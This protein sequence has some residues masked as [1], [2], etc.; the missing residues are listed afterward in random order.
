MAELDIK[1]KVAEAVK[2]KQKDK[3]FKDTS[4]VEYTRKYQAQYD[5]ITSKDLT[6]IEKDPITAYKL[7]D[8]AKIW[9]AYNVDQMK[10]DG[11][12]SGVAYLA[13]KVRESLSTKPEDSPKARELYVESVAA[14]IPILESATDIEKLKDLLYGFYKSWGKIITDSI[15]DKTRYRF[16]SSDYV[17]DKS[18]E[19][20]WGKRFINQLKFSS[21]AAKTVYLEARM[22]SAFSIEEQNEVVKTKE[23]VYTERI[24]R[25]EYSI[26]AATSADSEEILKPVLSQY[27]ITYD[28]KI[29]LQSNKDAFIERLNKLIASS[30]SIIQNPELKP[31]QLAREDDWK[32]HGVKKAPA[33]KEEKDEWS[34]NILDFYGLKKAIKTTSLSYIK[35][36]Y[37]LPVPDINVESIREYFGYS[38]VVF[39][40]YV[41]DAESKE[42]VRHFLG[43]MVD[44]AEI[45]NVD[46]KQINKFGNLAIFFGALGCGSFSSA[47]ACYYPSRKA[48]NLTKKTGDGSLAHEWSHYLDN[49]CGESNEKRTDSRYASSGAAYLDNTNIKN[50]FQRLNA[51]IKAGPDFELGVV[52]SR[53]RK[54]K[55]PKYR[56]YGSTI[57][58]CVAAIQ[59]MYPKYKQYQTV[60]N[61][62]KAI[63]Y[64]RYIATKFNVDEIV[65]PMVSSTT[66]YY[67]V[68]S[69]YE[70]SGKLYW[71][72]PVELF[73][74]AFESYME[75]KL[76]QQER[77]SNYLVSI[78]NN[79]GMAAV[80]IPKEEWPYPQGAELER[81]VVAFDNL[82]KTIKQEF[83]IGDFSWF[84]DV[85][86][87]EYI[88]LANTTDEKIEAGVIVN[89]EEQVT[90]ID[91][92]GE[93]EQVPEDNRSEWDKTFD[94]NVGKVLNP[95]SE[96]SQ[97]VWDELQQRRLLMSGLTE[98]Q[99][100]LLERIPEEKQARAVEI[101][102]AA[103]KEQGHN[104][105]QI[106]DIAVALQYAYPV[107]YY[108]EYEFKEVVNGTPTIGLE[109]RIKIDAFYSEQERQDAIDA[110]ALLKTISNNV[111]K[112]K[113]AS[114]SVYQLYKTAATHYIKPEGKVSFE[115]LL[116]LTSDLQGVNDSIEAIKIINKYAPPVSQEEINYE[117]KPYKE[118][119]LKLHEKHGIDQASK[120]FSN[121][122]NYRAFSKENPISP[123]TASYFQEKFGTDEKLNIISMQQAA[124][125]FIEDSLKES[126]AHQAYQEEESLTLDYKNPFYIKW[127][128]YHDGSDNWMM[129]KVVYDPDNFTFIIDIDG[130]KI[131]I[132]AKDLQ[133]RLD[134][135]TYKLIS[136]ADFNSLRELATIA[137]DNSSIQPEFVAQKLDDTSEKQYFK[138]KLSAIKIAEKYADPESKEYYKSM[139][140]AVKIALKY[141]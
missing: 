64:Y 139:K 85:R 61:D 72:S 83:N 140:Q 138:D 97:K 5:I 90:V 102:Y 1:N 66:K 78:V 80:L 117:L 125:R 131:K 130:S 38:D 25:Y 77:H 68:S 7:I 37:G 104:N 133:G 108:E 43:A 111:S 42:H 52:F 9:P 51:A 57:E 135:G 120:E 60:R 65:V 30:R 2:E 36:T 12:R 113:E 29:S 112:I 6:D 33:T 82:I 49:I 63:E 129:A 81:I 136:E 17:D 109:Y 22:F 123:A 100:V 24:E 87:D 21:D 34:D 121:P 98:S 115:K 28:N 110:L 40:N 89:E 58:E 67:H 101:A 41:K 132:G 48:I 86:Q 26:I 75:Y 106:E 71:T 56:V 69:K 70:K 44:L 35:R 15:M 27:Y 53:F 74:R 124:K 19:K 3:V 62:K 122:I 92:K 137:K 84:S 32:W 128:A 50:A 94:I 134:S 54:E 119:A 96:E 118:W 79:L 141:L 105:I 4:V 59:R 76:E 55:Y 47:M 99:R 23:K 20:I 103:A 107:N 95:V 114:N 88:D 39:G 126:N 31:Y 11:I 127:E 14:L 13:V 91:N 46:L 10:A 18:V 93:M 8:K 73:A 116:Q 45:L 16:L